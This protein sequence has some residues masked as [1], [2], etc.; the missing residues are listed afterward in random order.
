[1][2]HLI[3]VVI[4]AHE[5]DLDTLEL[6]IKFVKS[7]VK[8]LHKIYIVSK[9]RLT[10]EA[11]WISEDSYPFTLQDVID[12]IGSH[13]RTCWYYAGLFQTTSLI[14]KEFLLDNVLILDCDTFFIKPVEFVDNNGISLFN[15]SPTDGTQPYY[16]YMGK[17]VKGLTKQ[18]A[19]SGT[20]HHILMNREILKSLFDIVEKKYQMP[21]W[22]AYIHV[23]LQNYSSI[24]NEHTMKNR[25]AEGPGRLS[26]Y[27]LYFNYALK[28]FPNK[29]RIR[30]LNS[31]FSYKG[32]IGVEGCD[33]KSYLSRT[34]NGKK[35]IIP[36]NIEQKFNFKNVKEALIYLSKKCKELGYDTVTFQNHTRIGHKNHVKINEN[37][38]KNLSNN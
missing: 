27:D 20:C 5:K 13:W 6:C 1:M 14:Y 31:I 9:N 28:Y 4:P 19:W 33:N 10:Q 16:E 15:I 12:M 2:V 36:I 35:Q 22:K 17:M 23:T 34:T 24:P 32:R 26:T 30:K 38:L 7:N 25:H 18:H 21:F 11:E 37:Y 3:D 29:C 8:N